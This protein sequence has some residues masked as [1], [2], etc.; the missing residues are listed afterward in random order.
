MPVQIA[1]RNFCMIAVA[2]QRLPDRFGQHHGTVPP[3][4]A[5]YRDCEIALPF[6]NVVRDQ[7]NQKIRYALQEFVR[8]REG[9]DIARHSRILA[10]KWTQPRDKVRVGKEAHIENQIGVGGHAIAISETDQ[11]NQKR[12]L[13][14]RLETIGDELAQLVNVE[15]GGINYNV[16]KLLDRRHHLALPPQ[17]LTHRAIMTER[18]RAAS[19]AESPQQGFLAGLDE[20]QLGGVSLAVKLANSFRKLQELTSLARVHQKGG[21]RNFTGS[22]EMHLTENGNQFNGKVVNAVEAQVFKRF[23]DGAL[24][25]PAQPGENH[26]LAVFAA[27]LALHR[28]ARLCLDPALVRAGNSENFAVF[29]DRAASD[30]NAGFAE[31]LRDG[32]IGERLRRV[33]FLDHFLHQTFQ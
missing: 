33:F 32:V 13:A 26:Q 19:F 15:L 6:L 22:G 12:A 11:R 2:R 14:A 3:A 18:V 8:L 1:V 16:R 23:E 10:G 5:A 29:R 31:F 4:R 20:H 9:F 7:I 24:S 25:R 27:G 21:A 17:S 30:L 28:R